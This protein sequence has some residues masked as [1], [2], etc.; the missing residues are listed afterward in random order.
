MEQTKYDVFISYSR[1]D[2]VDDQKNVIP[3]NEVSKIKNALTEAGISYWFDEEGIYSGQNF[4]EKIVTNIENAK[5][6]LFLSTANANKSPWTCKEIASADEFKKHII[7]VR[8]D[9]T[10]Y[11]KKVLFRIAD[12]DYIEYYTNP[13]KGIV[14]LVESINAY[15]KALAAE[16]KRKQ[17]EEERKKELVRRKAEELKERQELEDKRRRQEQEELAMSIYLEKEVL[18]TNETKLMAERKTLLLKT[19]KLSD[20]EKRLA[21]K[22]EIQESSPIACKVRE[23]YKDLQK[24]LDKV[25]AEN[26]SSRDEMH[27]LRN[28]VYDKKE[29]I[30]Q[31]EQRLRD[32][33]KVTIKTKMAYI[34]AI[35]A[36]AMG[37]LIWIFI[38]RQNIRNL[39]NHLHEVELEL[40]KERQCVEEAKRQEKHLKEVEQIAAKKKVKFMIEGASFQMIPVKGGTF[41]MGTRIK[42]SVSIANSINHEREAGDDESPVH[43]VTLSDYYIGETEVTQKLW[44]TV[45][46][47]NPSNFKGD[48]LLPVESVNVEDINDFLYELNR[49]TGWHFRL[50]TEAEWEFAA[51]GGYHR[52]R[53]YDGIDDVA[54][55]RENSNSV[56]HPVG[57]MLNNDLG[58]YDMI[59]NVWEWCQDWYGHYSDSTQLD[60]K[61]P[62]SGTYRVIRGGSWRSIPDCC[63]VTYRG[64]SDPY[65]RYSYIGFRL[66]LSIPSELLI[67]EL[68]DQHRQTSRDIDAHDNLEF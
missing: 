5:V 34:I 32:A 20:K 26:V 11:N 25:L 38:D 49:L 22:T 57:K 33:S 1:K 35:I 9:S 36:I 48:L 65:K 51:R 53:D 66:A 63:R 61:G 19:E 29:R 27:C 23:E 14:D 15:L 24:E 10:P 52:Y 31:L 40:H 7:P 64:Y 42:N 44:K 28:E 37:L 67:D 45:M 56:T 3:G 12:L 21:L 18:N 68:P 30:A 13:Q 55:Y 4:V 8:I 2:Y 43:I 6:F 47:S 16:E 17:E 59:G 50:P 39:Q 62:S 58:L 54:W 60:P 46:G 41:K